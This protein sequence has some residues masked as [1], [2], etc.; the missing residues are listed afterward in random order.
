MSYTEDSCQTCKPN[1]QLSNGLCVEVDPNCQTYDKGE[2]KL[3]KNGFVLIGGKCFVADPNCNGYKSD[4]SCFKCK[5]SCYFDINNKCQPKD[6]G[7]VYNN[8]KCAYCMPPFIYDSAASTCRISYCQK[9]DENGCVCCKE[10]FE[11]TPS[12]ECS[13]PNCLN[14]NNG[15]CAQCQAQYHLKVGRCLANHPDCRSYNLEGD[16]QLCR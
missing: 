10:P 15:V 1:Y 2:C 9:T 3:C 13:L 7:C 14:I 16:C 4:G 11:L 8:G 5:E 12:H 6:H